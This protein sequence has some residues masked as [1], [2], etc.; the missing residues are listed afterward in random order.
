MSDDSV[1]SDSSGNNIQVEGHSEGGWIQWFC[2]L[3]GNE[4][5]VEVDED[6][7]RDPFNLYDLKQQID[8]TRFK[9]SIWFS[10]SEYIN[11]ILS[12]RMPKETELQDEA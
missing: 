5:L 9:Y 2:S 10:G 1:H 8:P 3:E 6:Y 4:F 11:L 12:P 7:L